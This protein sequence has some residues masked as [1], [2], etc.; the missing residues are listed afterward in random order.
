MNRAGEPLP[1]TEGIR[2][3]DAVREQLPAIVALLADDPLGRDRES[4][5]GLDAYE[6]A[7]AAIESDPAHRLLVLLDD[8]DDVV[9]VMQL[10]Y[11]P[12]LSRGGALRAQIEGVRVSTRLRG[13]G[14]GTAFFGWAV[15]QARVEG[16]ALVQLTTDLQ[17]P[18][19]LRFYESLGFVASHHGLK[20]TLG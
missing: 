20:L 11:L 6:T 3:A 19:A 17:R 8:R 14:V 5:Q 18:A 13:T 1:G 4:S 16:A 9:A 15:E 10:S 12:G 7:F 2:V